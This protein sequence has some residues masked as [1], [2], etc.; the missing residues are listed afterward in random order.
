[1]PHMAFG[2]WELNDEECE[3]GLAGAIEEG[4][5]LL[6]FAAVYGNEAACGRA[7]AKV[8][9]AGKVK[10]EELFIVGKLWATDWH[11]VDVACTK[12]LKDLQLDYLDLYLVHSTVG[13]DEAAGLDSKGNV[14]RSKVPNHVLW[15]EM[16][17]L[18]EAGLVES[19]GTSNW[20]ILQLVDC[21]N[22]AKIPPSLNQMEMHPTYNRNE[23]AQWCLGEGIAVMGYCTLGTGKPDLTLDPVTKPAKRCG[24]S[25]HQVIIKWSIQKGYC[26]ITKVLDRPLMKSNKTLNFELTAEEIDA[27]DACDG[28]LPMK[29]VNHA[30]EFNL[31]L[32]SKL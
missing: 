11:Q 13:V 7:L 26:P 31:P 5:R 22:Y 30:K 27:I 32:Y 12:S 3:I 23:F 17:K 2:F 10:R 15:G 1:M 14:T 9:A 20:G 25:P 4:Y 29:I 8:L 18:V 24:V 28:D 21:L 19:I 6:D 16:E